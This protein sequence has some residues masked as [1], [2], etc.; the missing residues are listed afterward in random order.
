MS[1]AIRQ[2][3][4]GIITKTEKVI[5]GNLFT[6]DF[7]QLKCW[8]YDF[9]NEQKSSNG[10]NDCLCI[11]Y[12][13]KGTLFFNLSHESYEMHSGH[14]I[15]DKPDYEYRLRPSAGECT[16]FNFTDDFYKRFSEDMN[17]C[18]TFFFFNKNILS[19][20]LRSNA[21]T[22]YLHHQVMRQ[23]PV[24]G[25]LEMDN[26]VLDFFNQVVGI[27]TNINVDEQLNRKVS[28]KRLSTVEAAK[29][30][31]HENF[32]SD[33]SLSEIAGH[34]FVS[35]F[36]F[37]RLFKKF[38]FFSPYQYLQNTR[39][40]HAELLLKNSRMTVTDISYAAGF[41]STEYFATAFKQRYRLSPTDY[42]R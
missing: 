8:D 10:Y 5:S 38:T 15:I 17:I 24:A 4:P 27:I 12:V 3:T 39:L 7:Y 16:I 31:M 25:K 42:R 9:S 22:D 1:S 2:T 41:S 32:S 34:C 14:I 40:K 6:S 18:K 29:A 21:E 37:S 36:H 13:K 23:M 20:L 19:L 28:T 30:Y 35:P 26:M 11:L 33:I